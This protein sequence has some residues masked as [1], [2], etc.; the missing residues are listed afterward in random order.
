MF[1]DVFAENNFS[2]LITGYLNLLHENFTAYFPEENVWKV[3]S[4]QTHELYS[5]LVMS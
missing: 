2:T 1:E 5:P 3:T 4:K